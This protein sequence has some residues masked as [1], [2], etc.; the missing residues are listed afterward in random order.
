MYGWKDVA[1]PWLVT[2][3]G[4]NPNPA[5]VEQT[6]HFTGGGG[7]KSNS[8]RDLFGSGDSEEGDNPPM[9]TNELKREDDEGAAAKDEL[10]PQQLD[11]MS[12]KCRAARE[13]AASVVGAA[14]ADVGH[15]TAASAN[16]SAKRS[17]SDDEI[18]INKPSKKF[19]HV[20]FNVVD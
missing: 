18:K 3:V 16:A 6:F 15:Y 1:M 19:R 11:L 12:K 4:L 20:S 14:P 17:P 9:E 8:G 5:V 7:S 10:T 2:S 13:G